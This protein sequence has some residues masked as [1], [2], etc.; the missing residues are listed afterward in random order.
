LLRYT[1]ANLCDLCIEYIHMNGVM[2][3]RISPMQSVSG[4]GM[5]FA[6]PKNAPYSPVGFAGSGITGAARQLPPSAAVTSRE[7][8]AYVRQNP[9]VLA[10]NPPNAAIAAGPAQPQVRELALLS[11]DVYRDVAI[12]PSGYRVAVDG[13]LAKLGLKPSDLTST[14]SPFRAR[15]YVK[16]AGAD[17]QYV[18][19]F[20]GSTSGSDWRSNFQQGLGL[21]S[22]HYRK[23]L[24]I[25]SKLALATNANITITGHSLG[26]GLASATA[27]ASGR[28]AATFNSAGLSDA[29]IKQARNI[30]DAS[31]VRTTDSVSAYYVRG[32]ILSTLQD[33]GDRV[34][35]G[36]LGGLIGAGVVDAPEAYGRRIGLDAVRPEG[37]RWYQDN[38]GARHGM[39]WVLQS[40][41]GN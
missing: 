14:Q 9:V 38:P 36:L 25:G 31:N 24:A 7:V 26:G 34:I 1:G 32:E 30:H 18:V 12:P 11:A 23:A 39:N 6:L 28:N 5:I 17:A 41:N 21:S 13:D 29:T 27:I 4:R 40:L 35:G 2:I 22:D 16:G 3:E 37:V 8:S 33:G 19:A 10:Q 20:R 15:V